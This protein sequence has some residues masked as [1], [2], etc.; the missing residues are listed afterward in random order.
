M[1]CLKYAVS[2]YKTI[3]NSTFCPISKGTQNRWLL[4]ATLPS[5]ASHLIVF[6]HTIDNNISSI[7]FYINDSFNIGKR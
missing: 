1:L 2:L 4:T 6:L 7:K 5:Y 3:F